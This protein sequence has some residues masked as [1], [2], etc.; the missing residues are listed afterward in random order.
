[1]RPTTKDYSVNRKSKKTNINGVHKTYVRITITNQNFFFVS[2]KKSIWEPHKWLPL[3][4]LKDIF[5]IQN[6]RVT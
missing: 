5:W 2:W 4:H 6:Q 3:L 1:M